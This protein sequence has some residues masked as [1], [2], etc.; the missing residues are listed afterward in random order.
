MLSLPGLAFASATSSRRLVTPRSGRDTRISG[1]LAISE[2]GVKSLMASNGFFSNSA[3][4]MAWL[5]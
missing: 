4:L 1:E 2:I 3:G 5:V